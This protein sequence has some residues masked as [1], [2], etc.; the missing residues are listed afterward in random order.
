[1]PNLL[2]IL[3]WNPRTFLN[4]FVDLVPALLAP[5]TCIGVFHS[6]VDL[7]CL[8]CSADHRVGVIFSV[9]VLVDTIICDIHCIGVDAWVI[10]ITVFST[11]N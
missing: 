5:D 6:L 1:M 11:Y 10:V 2:K 7:P 9:T 3:A 4:E 8:S